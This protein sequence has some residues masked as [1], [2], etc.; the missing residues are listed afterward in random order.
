MKDDEDRTASLLTPAKLAQLASRPKAPVNPADWLDKMAADAGQA[1]VR[2]LAE[3]R[4]D[5]QLQATKRDFEPLAADLEAVAA[6]L[7]QL[8]FGLL[9]QKSGLLS[10]LSGKAKSA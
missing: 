10:R 7:P 8:D 3:L 2:R 1:H 5:L 4:A 9:Q 6:S